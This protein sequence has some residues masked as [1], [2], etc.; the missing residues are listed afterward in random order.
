[1]KESIFIA[2]D[3]VKEYGNYIALNKVSIT[4]PKGSIYGLLGPNGAGKTTLMRIINQITAPDSGNLIFDGAPLSKHHISDIGYL[5]EERG[6]Y[7]KMKVGEQALYLA[8]LKGMSYDEALEKLKFWFEKLDILS[9]WN[10]KVE[11]LSKGMAQKIQFVVTVIHEPKL[12]IFDEPF[13]GFDPIN[14]AIIRK[15]ILELSEKGTTIIF[16]T[17]RMESVE[18]IC[19]HIALINKAQ[20]I[21]EGPIE[22]IKKQFANNS[23]EVITTD[24]VLSEN[25]YFSIISQKESNYSLL[26]KEGK[27]QQEALQS[28][29]QQTEIISFRKEIPSMEEIFIKAINNA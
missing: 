13:S 6:L 5:P 22:E 19:D 29:I 2:K 1:M 3:V 12:L 17:H 18:E 11:E 28:I 8:Q 9:W 4:V 24:K 14:A 20:T 10:K 25:D 21:L 23:Y 26:L 15:E 7:K 16:S 27:T